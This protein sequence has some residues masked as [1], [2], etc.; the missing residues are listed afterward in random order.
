[1]SSLKASVSEKEDYSQSEKE[2]VCCCDCQSIIQFQFIVCMYLFIRNFLSAQ[3]VRQNEKFCKFN[4]AV[5]DHIQTH[6]KEYST[7]Y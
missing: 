6:M 2:C 1:M 5:V 3:T 4:R 7:R